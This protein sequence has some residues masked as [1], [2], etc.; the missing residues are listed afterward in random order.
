MK[1]SATENISLS[2][3]VSTLLILL[4][5]IGKHYIKEKETSNIVLVV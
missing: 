1:G 5:S 4:S 2:Q 3:T